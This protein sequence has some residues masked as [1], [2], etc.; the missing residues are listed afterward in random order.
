MIQALRAE[1]LCAVRGGRRLFSDLALHLRAGEA[2]LLQGP[3]GSGKTTLLR[4]LAGLFAPQAGR[5]VFEGADGPL[6][7]DRARS[8]HTHFL[9]HRDGLKNARTAGEELEFWSRWSEG[10]AEAALAGGDPLGLRPL[11]RL[12]VVN[13]SAGQRRRL[14][15]ARL[16]AAPRRLWLLDEPMAPLDALQRR[17]FGALME[18]HL[19]DG[20]LVVAAAHDPLPVAARCVELSAP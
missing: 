4:T 2:V 6:E 19:Q 12:A 20:G 1:G 15:L 18:R 10:T 5:I 13:L 9:S 11:L 17:R 7:P 16:L 8:E 14:A 3:N